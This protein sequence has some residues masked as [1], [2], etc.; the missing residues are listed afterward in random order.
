M[1]A[2]RD[3]W[4][5]ERLDDMSAVMADGFNRTDADLRA[6]RSD[7]T[8]EFAAVRSEMRSEFAAVRSEMKSEFAA[9]R[10]EM[11][12]EFAASRSAMNSR[13]EATQRLI[14]QVGAGMFGTMVIGFVSLVVTILLT[15]H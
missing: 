6:L 2:V 14:V 7:M 8:S 5:D 15:Q 12:S 4:T 13:F 11:R 3:K 1:E 9:V 10:S